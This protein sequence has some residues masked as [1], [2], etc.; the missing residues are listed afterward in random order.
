MFDLDAKAGFHLSL[1]LQPFLTDIGHSLYLSARNIL[2]LITLLDL[3]IFRGKQLLGL[4]L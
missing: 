2:S 1:T 4:K 3:D